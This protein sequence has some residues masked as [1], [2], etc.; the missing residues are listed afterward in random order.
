MEARNR[1]RLAQ[2][3]VQAGC[4]DCGYSDHPAALQFDHVRGV[5]VG[6]ISEMV[7]RPWKVILTEV[8]K[9][10]VVCAVHHAIRSWERLTAA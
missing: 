3:K 6:N 5:K 8:E 7:K 10:E 9:C 4:A 2:I 1:Q